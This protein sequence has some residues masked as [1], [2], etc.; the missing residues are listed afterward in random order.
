M[1]QRIHDHCQVPGIYH[2]DAG[3]LTIV[4]YA[5]A[6]PMSLRAA[7]RL[8]AETGSRARVLDLRWLKP[9]NKEVI[10]REAKATGRL[11]V[12]DE[13]RRTGSLSEE[14]FT[15]LDETVGPDVTRMRVV[16]D[17]TYIPLGPAANFVLP[18]EDD[19]L[20]RAHELLKK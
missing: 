12:V 19:I 17:D 20:A 6:V 2:A 7:R 11:L 8:E 14:I 1:R 4:T 15:L 5:N 13:G 18:G 9:L 3:D 10:A 16:G